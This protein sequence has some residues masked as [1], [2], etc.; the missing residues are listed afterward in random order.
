MLSEMELAFTGEIIQWNEH[1]FKNQTD[2]DTGLSF[3]LEDIANSVWT[4]ASLPINW[5]QL[6]PDSNS[7]PFTYASKV[8]LM[9]LLGFS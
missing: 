4:L 9:S 8:N 5:N 2:I 3:E 6:N 7:D 1:S